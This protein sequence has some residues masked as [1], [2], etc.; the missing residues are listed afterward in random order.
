MLDSDTFIPKT[1]VICNLQIEKA[2][3]KSIAGAILIVIE[4]K[5]IPIEKVM[6]LGSD[7]A[8]VMTGTGKGVTG[9][10]LRVNPMLLN[11]HCIAHR[12]ALVSSKAA[13]EVPYLKEY[14]DI[15][16]SMFYF[17]KSSAN[18]TG[19]LAS[20]QT[21]LEEPNLKIKEVHEVRWLSLCINAWT[22]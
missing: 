20:V 8:K 4:G 21:L 7:G 15:L 12:L 13:N 5:N 19:Q 10:L 1:H 6:G 16:C 2:D 22:R 11:F 9:H 18:R 14:Q 3:G 17:F